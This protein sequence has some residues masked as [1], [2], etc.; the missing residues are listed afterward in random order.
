MDDKELITL[1]YVKIIE[2][3][4]SFACTYLGKELCLALK[5]SNKREEVQR[6]LAI[7]TEMTELFA[8]IGNT[9]ISEIASVT[10]PFKKLESNLTLSAKELLD[11]SAI[12][13]LAR[14]LKAYFFYEKDDT[15]QT[16]F[17]YLY[18]Y[19]SSLYTN[20]GIEHRIFVSILDEDT[21]SDDASP[22]LKAIRNNIRKA[23]KEIKE[24][25]NGMIHSASFSKYLQEPVVT[26]RSDRFVL[27]VKEE[28]RSMVKGFIHDMSASGSTVFMEPTSVFELNNKIAS[29]RV[30]EN[31]EIGK[32]LEELSLLFVPILAEIKQNVETIG[33]LD[34]YSAK[35]LYAKELQATSPT[36]SATKEIVLKKARH[37]LL[38]KDTVVP[39]DI[40]LGKDYR[41]LVITGPNTGGKTVTLK[42]VGLLCLMA[43]AGLHIPANEGSSIYVFDRIFADIGDE[44]SIE[45]S[46]S[47]FSSHM[48]NIASIVKEATSNSLVLL[49]E[50][51]SGTDPQE[52]SSLA[53]SVL[54]YLF[55][56]G[57][58]L[59]ATTHYPEM[60]HYALVTKGFENA[61]CEFDVE[62]LK[63]TYKLLI[64]IPGKSNA[65]AISKRLGLLD[66]I[67]EN[68]KH[69]L[70]PD[71]I[72]IEELLK[73]IYDNK[74]KIEKEKEEIEKNKTQ[75]ENLR[76][77]LE[78]EDARVKEKEQVILEK[79]KEQARD[80]LQSAK[81]TVAESIKELN[82]I[83][84]DSEASKKANQIRN[85]LN[86]SMKNIHPQV[87]SSASYVTS[88]TKQEIQVGM[89]VSIPHLKQTGTILSLP[90]KEEQVTV[91]IG[92][93]KMQLPLQSL[94]KL[95]KPIKKESTS[96]SVKA[97][98][99]FLKSKTATSEIN[100]IG[101]TVE[102]AILVIDKFLDD[103]SL[104]HLHTV[105][106]VHGKGTGALRTGIHQ[107]LKKHPHVSSYRIGSFGEGEMGVTIVEIK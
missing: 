25:L 73:E 46:L 47:T 30:E 66:Q 50:L 84:I 91:Q 16:T 49:D 83:S 82:S 17:P 100:V 15:M 12:L 44:Q 94:T 3:L 58:L 99:S 53:I 20:Q 32:I 8:H 74:L 92:N 35:A 78:K 29:L 56:K 89:M 11:I 31:I 55:Q 107:F 104:S 2:N 76:K 64:G 90:N 59:L 23:E 63:P 18:P 28:Y 45:A 88:L 70:T 60:K 42:T 69:Y 103:A 79:A 37:P 19:F 38:A 86:E 9:P 7:T 57:A 54:D 72:S 80:M 71:S 97:N 14:V 27:P 67:L 85:R 81:K 22:A 40:A 105:R 39:I 41:C 36:L 101:L 102:E 26:I 43:C 77:S 106:I 34:L 24:K 93:M 5:P 98:S 13:K 61:S 95:D 1:E 75:I 65:F 48:V 6:E 96:T 33:K 62:K 4:A 21:I 68:A 51:G 52:G 10:L 87:T